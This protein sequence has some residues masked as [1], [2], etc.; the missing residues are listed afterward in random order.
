MPEP[1]SISSLSLPRGTF[2]QSTPRKRRAMGGGFLARL[3][4]LM[5]CAEGLACHVLGEATPTTLQGRD[6]VEAIFAHAN[7][8]YRWVGYRDLAGARDWRIAGP[9]FS[10]ET[11][12]G[13]R[14]N[15]DEPG[16]ERLVVKDHLVELETALPAP[17]IEVRQEF[18]FCPDGRTLRIRT[19]LRSPRGTGPGEARRPARTPSQRAGFPVDGPRV[20]L[21]AR[22]RR[23]PLCRTSSIRRPG[24]RPRGIPSRWRNPSMSA[25]AGSGLALPGAVLGSASEKDVAMAGEE[26][27]AARVP[28]LPRHRARQAQGPARALQRLVDGA[29]S[30][31]EVNSCCATS[32]S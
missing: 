28:A 16:F 6:G 27:V 9:R 32:P 2:S 11:S 14:V 10:F 15:L 20:C 8:G 23:P 24:A 19:F 26:G 7:G 13:R 21:L 29:R 31:L 12:D 22:L 5:L 17:A 30:I 4:A 18:S 1:T 25:W 3:T